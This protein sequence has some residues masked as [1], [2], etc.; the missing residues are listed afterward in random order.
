M[1]IKT[2][3]DINCIVEI[4]RINELTNLYD[5]I[6]DKCRPTEKKVPTPVNALHQ[7][8]FSFS[9]TAIK[10]IEL[11]D[12]TP[13]TKKAKNAFL[14]IILRWRDEVSNHYWDV[15]LVP[16]KL[17]AF[18]Q[19]IREVIEQ[20]KLDT[21]KKKLMELSIKSQ[22]L[23]QSITQLE[24]EMEKIAT[25]PLIK[26]LKRDKTNQVYMLQ[27]PG[28]DDEPDLHSLKNN[29]SPSTT[30]SRS[31]KRS[32]SA[33]NISQLIKDTGFD[34]D[35]R[36]L[37]DGEESSFHDDKD[38]IYELQ[39]QCL[40][41]QC[42]VKKKHWKLTLVDQFSAITCPHIISSI[43]KLASYP[44]I[45]HLI[46][47][48]L[49]KEDIY[50]KL[51][52]LINGLDLERLNMVIYGFDKHQLL[53]INE[54]ISDKHYTDNETMTN[55][56]KERV[57]DWITQCNQMKEKIDKLCEHLRFDV[58]GYNLSRK[59]LDA[60]KQYTQEVQM[61]ECVSR[62]IGLL[63]KNVVTNV[64]WMHASTEGIN[65][66][67]QKF[68]TRL[69]ETHGYQGRESG[70]VWGI[71]YRLSF[72]RLFRNELSQ[73]DFLLY[74]D[75]DA[76]ETF[77]DWVITH[78]TDYKKVGLLGDISNLQ[79]DRLKQDKLRLKEV[80]N[81]VLKKLGIEK[82]KHWK[83]KEIFN[84]NLFKEFLSG[85]EVRQLVNATVNELLAC[86]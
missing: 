39:A 43:A 52:H 50:W 63:T 32:R 45:K 78:P 53:R 2:N 60:I 37:S 6:P 79:F 51:G 27:P 66:D 19:A 15:H 30:E 23:H 28:M 7:S 86:D 20:N 57:R 83:Q 72:E 59:E 24:K 10:A 11:A 48:I 75:R 68:L 70:C 40:L 84:F 76:T 36:V 46:D 56:F 82:I 33:N 5:L 47:T 54:I 64:E 14:K 18:Q 55:Y 25:A 1:T 13:Q 74:D 34:E 81:A 3:D 12:A 69:T 58:T 42:K 61:L 65:K 17:E 49:G 35:D 67:Y 38:I 21:F 73:G 85:K 77:A 62:K 80:A 16:S 31:L 26:E 44:Q 29:S 71:I 22:T 41:N 4:A 9:S 8:L